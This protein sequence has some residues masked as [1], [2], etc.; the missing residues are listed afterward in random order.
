MAKH[1]MKRLQRPYDRILNDKLKG[2][3]GEPLA[4][5]LLECRVV[6]LMIRGGI[7]FGTAC[8]TAELLAA[9]PTQLAEMLHKAGNEFLLRERETS[10]KP[11]DAQD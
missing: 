1:Q 7:P 3:T 11:S 6:E 8:R 4:K 2:L 9:D 10:V 5:K